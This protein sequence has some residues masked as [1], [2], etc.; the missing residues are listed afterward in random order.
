ME[1][2]VFENVMD[3]GLRAGHAPPDV[4]VL[5]ADTVRQAA[6]GIVQS[7]RGFTATE[8]CRVI[9]CSNRQPG[10]GDPGKLGVDGWIAKSSMR[11][12]RTTLEALFKT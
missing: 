10:P 3:L 11:E 12:L 2:E 1:V 8:T 4:I 7:L 5:D 6:G 9:L